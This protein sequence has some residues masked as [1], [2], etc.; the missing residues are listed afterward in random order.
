MTDFSEAVDLRAATESRRSGE[1]A[2]RL[3]HLGKGY[4]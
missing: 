4:Y 1:S 3:G 2:C